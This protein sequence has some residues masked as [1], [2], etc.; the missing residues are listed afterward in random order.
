MVRFPRFLIALLLGLLSYSH[1]LACSMMGDWVKPTNFELVELADAIVIAKPMSQSSF[2]GL[3]DENEITFSI[4]KTIKGEVPKTITSESGRLGIFVRKSDANSISDAHWESFSGPCSR[5]T[6]KRGNPYVLFLSKRKDGTLSLGITAFSRDKED[7]AGPDSLWMKTISY[8]L[9]VQKMEDPDV[10]LSTLKRK[11]DELILSAAES[12]ERKL[13]MDIAEHFSSMSP[14]KPSNFLLENYKALT[15]G[16]ALPFGVRH[17]DANREGGNAELMTDFVL[18]TERSDFDVENKK[19]YILRSL[20]TAGHSEL[21]AKTFFE[22]LYQKD[23][24]VAHLGLLL[25]YLGQNGYYDDALALARQDIIPA[26]ETLKEDDLRSLYSGM[27]GMHENQNNWRHPL[28]MDHADAKTW[29]PEF[30]YE[31]Q[32]LLNARF[33]TDRSVS[34]PVLKALRP[35]NYRDRP[36]ITRQL[37]ALYDEEEAIRWAETELSALLEAGEEVDSKK[38][39]LPVEVLLIDYNPSRPEALDKVFCNSLTR[40]P[41]LSH[42]DK[43]TEINRDDLSERFGIQHSLMSV[44]EK[45]VFLEAVKRF[46]KAEGTDY[47]YRDVPELD[48]VFDDIVQRVSDGADIK[49]LIEDRYYEYRPVVCE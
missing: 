38:F 23:N 17:P 7:Y 3:D 19:A 39:D 35:G 48:N 10:Q 25:A 16:Q 31:V 30:A 28:W 47:S 18:G 45:Q 9:D 44:D 5:Q 41:L 43:V 20:A 33:G 26:I 14:Y 1:A 21:N 42:L 40:L 6:F 11:Y 37:A 32:G 46:S 27:Y 22:G 29:W 15:T 2:F 12:D 34:E 8:Y 49:P 24:S 4:V 36:D 13:T